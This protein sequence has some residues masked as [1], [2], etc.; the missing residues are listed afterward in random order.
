MRVAFGATAA[1]LARQ[2]GAASLV[3]VMVLFF[4]M[5]L[6]AAYTSRNLIFEQRTSVNQYRATQ[7]FE[8]AEA[9]LEWALAQLNG[10]RI[11]DNCLE[12]GAVAT[13]L[14][15]RQRYL[16]IDA[17]APP[18]PPTGMITALTQPVLGNPPR[19]AGCVWNGGGWAC[20]CPTDTDP[21]LAAP[22]GNGVFPAF[23]VSFNTN[24]VTRPGVVQIVANGCTRLDADCLRSLPG[25]SALE[26]RAMI[27]ELLAL[28]SA[29]TTPPAAALTTLGGAT[30]STVAGVNTAAINRDAGRGGITVQAGGN[31]AGDFDLASTP[32]TPPLESVVES[33]TSLSSLLLAL[34][35]TLPAD[36]VAAGHVPNDRGFASTFGLW[37]GSYRLQPAAVQLTCPAGGCSAALANAAV[38]NPGR[39]IWIDGN[40]TVEAAGDI[41]SAAEPVTII[42]AGDGVANPGNV[43][44]AAG[45]TVYGLVYARGFGSGPGPGPD[46]VWRGPGVVRGAVIVEGNYAGTLAPTIEFDGAIVDTLR[47][48]AGSFVRVPG[49]WRDFQ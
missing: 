7:A 9:G 31:V 46:I 41:G 3:V 23:W 35:T 16:D 26:G 13:S 5:A 22:A 18:D 1:P 27:V 49:S 25:D 21:V 15:F 32:G 6:V 36:L 42:V 17:T 14:S 47:L 48:R 39:V 24:G 40:L 29:V 11:D 19:R 28:K 12:A 8:A 10:G 34:P 44:L 20:S 2:R 38:M 33:D 43:S 45:A 37:P 4:V 30:G